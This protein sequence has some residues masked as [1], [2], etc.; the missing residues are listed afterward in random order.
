[1]E[2]VDRESLA[3]AHLRL[4]AIMQRCGP[5]IAEQCGVSYPVDLE[6]AVVRYVCRELSQL[7][8][9]KCLEDSKSL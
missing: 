6:S 9:E 1:M 4:V 7:G 2:G 3:K 5:S 8:L